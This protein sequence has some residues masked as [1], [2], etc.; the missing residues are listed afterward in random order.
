MN[1]IL[2]YPNTAQKV[3]KASGAYIWIN[4]KRFIDTSM[5]SGTH[6][7]G[8]RDYIA[9]DRGTLYGLRP[10][11]LD[12]YEKLLSSYTQF[13][14]FILCNSGSEATMRAG[15]IARA[16]TGRD[17]IG[18]FEGGWHG[19]CDG[20]LDCAGIPKI[21]QELTVRLPYDDTA[22]DIIGREELA[23]VIV[24]PV[25][26]SLP[27]DNHPFLRSLRTITEKAGTLLC[28]DEVVNGFR[29]ARG[30][31]REYFGV[32]CDLA[33]YGKIAGGGF[34]IGIVAGNGELEKAVQMDVFL[35]GTFSG[36]PV[37]ISNGEFVL[38]RL[39]DAVYEYINSQ[40]ERLR[41]SIK[42]PCVGVG[43]ITRILFT[44]NNVR[45]RKERDACEDLV[46]KEEFYRKLYNKGVLVGKNGIMFM[47]SAHSPD[48]VDTI[49]N[50]INSSC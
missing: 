44:E 17:K 28:F 7:L 47:S 6:I 16:V 24:E 27:R 32:D 26:G 2:N 48:I 25:Q 33:T 14:N 10:E 42:M 40:A 50:T 29:L 41:N 43:S 45:N 38:S 3:S 8:H 9:I 49:I 37:S 11:C 1:S 34:P 21:L 31:G 4:G 22:L 15:R 39:S 20:W 19:S 35:G 18:I 36:N 23:M 46:W 5:G 13:S 12:R 30:G